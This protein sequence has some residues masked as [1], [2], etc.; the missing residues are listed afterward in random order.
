MPAAWFVEKI[1]SIIDAKCLGEGPSTA[2]QCLL[3]MAILLLLLLAVLLLIFIVMV[4]TVILVVITL[5]D[6]KFKRS[7]SLDSEDQ[8][9]ALT[10]WWSVDSDPCLLSQKLE[11]L[12]DW[13][14]GTR[15]CWP[16]VVIPT[17]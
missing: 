7:G 17:D 10:W 11:E 4:I 9:Q 8:V 1:K 5:F 15:V 16:Q 12:P 14:S 13:G 3:V 2:Y 6:T